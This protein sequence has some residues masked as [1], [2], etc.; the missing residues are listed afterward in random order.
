MSLH[1]AEDCFVPELKLDPRPQSASAASITSV[2]AEAPCCFPSPGGVASTLAFGVA[3]RRLEDPT[4]CVDAVLLLL[5][6]FASCPW[7]LL[8]VMASC[9][10]PSSSVSPPASSN[11]GSTSSSSSVVSR[12]RL[13]DT[14]AAAHAHSNVGLPFGFFCFAKYTYSRSRYLIG[15]SGELGILSQSLLGLFGLDWVRWR[16]GVRTG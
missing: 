5:Q 14:R 4:I 8:G 15:L 16:I 3:R 13:L 1:C 6:I 9:A 11:M 7:L 2:S 10:S 12:F